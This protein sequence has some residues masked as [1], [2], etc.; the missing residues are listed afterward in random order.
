[1]TDGKE[2]FINST[3]RENLATVGSG[4]V[5]AGIIASLYAQTKNAVGSAVAGVYVH[6]LCGDILYN[7][8]GSS[9]T[10]ASELIDKISKAKKEILN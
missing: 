10:L 6:G 9:S 5:L 4:D 7:E 2:F 1:M 8:T 3:G